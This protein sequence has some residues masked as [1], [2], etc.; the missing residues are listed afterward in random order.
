MWSRTH[1]QVCRGGRSTWAWRMRQAPHAPGEGEAEGMGKV[2]RARMWIEAH[3]HGL[4]SGSVGIQ[5]V[6]NIRT[7]K[8][9]FIF[10]RWKAPA[11]SF[12]R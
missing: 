6:D 2:D 1:Q 3:R 11:T 12:A 5:C 7:M 4:V 9:D 8:M 10:L